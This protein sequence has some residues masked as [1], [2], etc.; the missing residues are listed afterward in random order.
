[1][2]SEYLDKAIMKTKKIAEV[3]VAITDQE[4]GSK[5]KLIVKKI[6][7]PDGLVETFFITDDKHSVQILPITTDNQ[8]VT[9]LQFRPNLEKENCE[10]P[11]G[12]LEKGEDPISAAERELLEET[13]YKGNLMHVYSAPYNPYSTGIRHFFVATDCV[14]VKDQI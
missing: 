3:P 12:G 10:L 6:Q 14:K 8:V 2:K 4:S 7:T 13:G 1:M 5:K 11:G 9:V